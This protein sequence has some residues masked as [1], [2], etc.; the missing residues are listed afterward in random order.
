MSQTGVAVLALNEQ[1]FQV[2]QHRLNHHAVI[3]G[4]DESD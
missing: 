2:N 1:R 4:K 3:S